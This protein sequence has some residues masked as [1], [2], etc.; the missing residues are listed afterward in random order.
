MLFPA[1]FKGVPSGKYPTSFTNKARGRTEPGDFRAGG[2]EHFGS[3]PTVGV[4]S[5]PEKSGDP[6]LLDV[7]TCRNPWANGMSQS[8]H[9]EDL[10][11]WLNQDGQE[12]DMR[13]R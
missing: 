5:L 4:M 2:E 13:T 11:D 1:V 10:Y 9:Q 3:P 7:P 8:V 12:R 6:L